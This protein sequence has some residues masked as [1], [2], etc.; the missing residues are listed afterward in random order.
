MKR[1]IQGGLLLLVLLIAYLVMLPSTWLDAVF[2][3]ETRGSFTMTGTSGTLWRGEGSLQAI[4]PSGEAVTLAPTN[5]SIALNEL[6]ALRLHIT[7]RSVQ[8]G[9]PILDVSLSPGETRIHEAKL[10]LPATL[11]GVLTPT[12][13]AAALSGQMALQATDMRLGDGHATGKARITW[14]AAG[15]ELSRVRPLGNYQLELDGQGGGLDF[16]LNTMGGALNLTG[17]GH[18]QPGMNMEYKIMAIPSADKRQ[19]LVPLLR[20]LGREISPG[21]YQ[22]SIDPSVQ[23]VSG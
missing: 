16:R 14:M 15:S 13:R 21:T 22:L 18:I 4:L 3:H 1:V 23:P 20:M 17:T 2:Q 11:L 10:E 19:D 7:I 8:S 9:S 6:L 12:L 5:W